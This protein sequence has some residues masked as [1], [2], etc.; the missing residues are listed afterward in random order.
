MNIIL[1]GIGGAI[2]SVLRM[3]VSSYLSKLKIFNISIGTLFVN[4]TGSILLGLFIR[5]N[6]DEKMYMLLGIGLLGGYTTFSTFNYELS[7][8]IKQKKILSS[9]CYMFFMYTLSI[10]GA[11][12]AITI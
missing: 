3:I 1:V 8:L 6:L 9:I 11:F 4:I 12:L 5:Y 7:G 10:I 2:G